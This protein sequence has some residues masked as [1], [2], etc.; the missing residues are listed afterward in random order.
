LAGNY[1]IMK[2]VWLSGRWLSADIITG[3]NYS[4]DVMQLDIN[5]RF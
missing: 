5:T 4:M 3:P 1:G 2:N